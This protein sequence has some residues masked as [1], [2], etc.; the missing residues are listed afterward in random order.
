MFQQTAQKKL[1]QQQYHKARE[2]IARLQLP[3][4]Q[5]ALL[6]CPSQ[7]YQGNTDP[8]LVKYHNSVKPLSDVSLMVSALSDKF[9]NYYYLSVDVSLLGHMSL[10]SL[11]KEIEEE[12]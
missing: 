12:D 11:L 9:E 2:V 10:K 8:I 1:N 5:L 6:S 4:W 7:S 3:S